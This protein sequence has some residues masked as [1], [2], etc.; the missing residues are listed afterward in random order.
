VQ[1]RPVATEVIV[2]ARLALPPIT[3]HLDDYNALVLS[4]ELAR[5]ANKPH[6]GFLIAEL[7]RARLCERKELPRNVVS[8]GCSVTYRLTS[9]GAKATHRLVFEH[10]RAK[11]ANGLSVAT[12]L[13]TALLGVRVGDRMS[14][15]AMSGQDLEVVVEQIAHP[16]SA[17]SPG[18]NSQ[19]ALDRRLDH[20]LQETFPASDPVSIVCT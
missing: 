7:R 12:P 6:A 10:E 3:I 11:C 4:A 15:R 16:V 20:A 9:S 1:L 17:G 8:M 14:F 13:G 5:R 19:E 2:N 18:L